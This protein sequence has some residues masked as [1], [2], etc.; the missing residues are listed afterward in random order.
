MILTIGFPSADMMHV[1][2]AL[3]LNG[4]CIFTLQS[5]V[6]INAIVNKKGTR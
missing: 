6:Q 5:Q 1:D 4:A 3:C 2:T